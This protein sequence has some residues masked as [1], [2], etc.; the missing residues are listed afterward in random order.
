MN[1]RLTSAVADED[2]MNYNVTIPKHLVARLIDY[3][4]FNTD[5]KPYFDGE[6]QLDGVDGVPSPFIDLVACI[7]DVHMEAR[8]WE[9]ILSSA[10]K[11]PTRDGALRYVNDLLEERDLVG[12]FAVTVAP[13]AGEEA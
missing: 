13:I 1:V 7:M 4:I 3:F 9:L 5:D 6:G 10:I 12:H 8:D 11:A 2:Q